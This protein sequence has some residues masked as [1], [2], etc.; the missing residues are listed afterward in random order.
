MTTDQRRQ[1]WREAQA[2]HRAG[3]AGVPAPC[4][5]DAAARSHRRNGEDCATCKAAEA[6]RKRK[7]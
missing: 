7:A 6:A 4:G 1:Q 3:L 2:R 5:T